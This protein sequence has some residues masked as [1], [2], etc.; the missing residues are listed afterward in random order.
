MLK[1][2][3]VGSVLALALSSGISATAQAGEEKTSFRATMKKSKATSLHQL[4]AQFIGHQTNLG[5]LVNVAD[6]YIVLE[7]D[8]D[9]II[10]Y[11]LHMIVSVRASRNEAH[12][13]PD[14]LTITLTNEPMGSGSK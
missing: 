14:E 3:I 4:L 12:A 10:S 11:P 1:K 2:L 7:E 6:D 13:Q 9:S 5:T 8:E